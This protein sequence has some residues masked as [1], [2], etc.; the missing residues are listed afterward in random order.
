LVPEGEEIGV[1]G[2]GGRGQRQLPRRAV[3]E[4]TQPRAEELLGLVL[5]ELKK[6][7]YDGKLAAGVVLT[8]GSAQ[9][10]GLLPL[11]EDILGAQVRLGKPAA[12]QGL[13]DVVQGPEFA[14]VVGLIQWG[15]KFGASGARLASSASAGEGGLLAKL[16]AFLKEYF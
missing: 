15:A 9:I 5:L 10:E 2:V 1:A 16:K 3:A 12:L 11:A 14:T 4:I 7:G 13:G 6:S 8:G